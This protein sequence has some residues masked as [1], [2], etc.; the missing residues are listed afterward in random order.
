MKKRKAETPAQQTARL[1]RAR[2]QRTA[3]GVNNVPPLERMRMCTAKV[4]KVD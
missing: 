2:D 1:E 4:I 3:V